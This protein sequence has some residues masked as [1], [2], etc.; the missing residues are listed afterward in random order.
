MFFEKENII[1]ICKRVGGN[2]FPILSR[3]MTFRERERERDGERGK[4][5]AAFSSFLG[6]YKLSANSAAANKVETKHS[7]KRRLKMAKVAFSQVGSSLSE[8][9]SRI[10]RYSR[11]IAILYDC[12]IKRNSSFLNEIPKFQ[13]TMGFNGVFFCESRH[14]GNLNETLHFR[15]FN[16]LT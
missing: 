6:D 16:S 13:Q 1:S 15:W 12:L 10:G 14:H 2:L 5:A 9:R 4:S 7:V 11:F 8:T 3:N